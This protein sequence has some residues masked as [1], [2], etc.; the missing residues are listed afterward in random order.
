MA[1]REENLKIDIL[2]NTGDFK[3][4][5]SGDLSRIKGLDNLNQALLHRLITVKGSLVHRQEYGI[6]IQEWQGQLTSLDK[7]RDLA[8]IIK[9]QYLRDSR[10]TEVNQ[11]QFIVDDYS[12]DL[13]KIFVKY[14]ALGY[15]DI[16]ETFDPFEIGE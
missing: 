7:Q 6:S 9:D 15:T 1:N 11:V 13:F 10:V 14:S 3:S 16:G 5:A 4:S 2:H 8:L 12:P